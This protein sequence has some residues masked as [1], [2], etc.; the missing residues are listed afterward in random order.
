MM[1]WQVY[2]YSWTAVL[3]ELDNVGMWNVRSQLWERQYLGQ[4][5]YMRV[6]NPEISFRNEAPIPTNVLLCGKAA[7]PGHRRHV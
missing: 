7:K 6:Y 1:W 3:M 4:Q 5:F 2:P